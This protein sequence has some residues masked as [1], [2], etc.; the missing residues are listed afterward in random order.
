MCQIDFKR[1]QELF[2]TSHPR[3]YL[4]FVF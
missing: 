1:Q 3:G 2:V 4:A